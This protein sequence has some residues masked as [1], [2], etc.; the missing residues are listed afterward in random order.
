MA[1]KALIQS[2]GDGTEVPSGSI[3]SKVDWSYGSSTTLSN[4]NT[5]QDVGGGSQGITLNKGCYLCFVTS[6]G[7][8]STS[9]MRL[10]TQVIVSSGTAILTKMAGQGDSVFVMDISGNSGT[11][12]HIFYA[13]VTVDSTVIKIQAQPAGGTYNNSVVVAGGAI[14]IA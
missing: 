1:N 2:G 7:T 3:L 13:V 11:S 10:F 6:N 9:N 5:M 12:S 8:P 14:R 4:N